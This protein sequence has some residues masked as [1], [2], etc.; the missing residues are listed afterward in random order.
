[1]EKFY[2]DNLRSYE[3]IVA[4]GTYM[5]MCANNVSDKHLKAEPDGSNARYI[6]QFMAINDDK[7]PELVALLK[8]NDEVD[9]KLT[10]GL[11]LTHSIPANNGR[12]VR[13]P[14]F[15]ERVECVVDWV[16]LVDGSK[17]L[18]IVNAKYRDPS[19]P[20][21]FDM[22]IFFSQKADKEDELQATTEAVNDGIALVH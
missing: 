7:L 8:D 15:K 20:P 10:E 16:P 9:I 13:L 1:M 12:E 22:S 14:M 2:R 5:L 6:V 17:A 19:R 4:P 11:F 21:K 18:R 3:H